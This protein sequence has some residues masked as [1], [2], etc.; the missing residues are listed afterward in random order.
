MKT[1]LDA[2]AI[3][4]FTSPYTHFVIVSAICSSNLN[5]C[6]LFLKAGLNASAPLTLTTSHLMS[7]GKTYYLEVEIEKLLALKQN[8]ILNDKICLTASELA[9]ATG[10]KKLIKLF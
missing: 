9:S 3:I 5:L 8:E 2:N 10:D 6:R 4:D 1:L 7:L